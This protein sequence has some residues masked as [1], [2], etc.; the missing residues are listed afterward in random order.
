LP[1]ER[2]LGTSFS[3]FGK[4]VFVPAHAIFAADPSRLRDCPV[5]LSLP[6]GDDQNIPQ[7]FP[8]CTSTVN[9]QSAKPLR[10][11][12]DGAM[13]TWR[14]SYKIGPTR[15]I[16]LVSLASGGCVLGLAIFLQWLIYNDWMHDHAQL[17]CV[18]S[19]IAAALTT[20][21]VMRWRLAHRRRRMEM[22]R[23]F[24][25]I[26]WMN[27]RIR[28]ALQTIELLAYANSQAAEAVSA[29]V[30]AIEDVLQEVLEETRPDLSRA[31]SQT[32]DRDAVELEE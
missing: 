31:S 12:E 25:T 19:L 6:F 24:E 17:R 32:R 23:R 7:R 8:S 2:R 13:K 15:A 22:L 16:W 30:D 4:I 10:T 21:I 27:D 29:A 11:A 5:R 26:R 20:F 18:G 28:N 1:I 9:R 14:R 3:R